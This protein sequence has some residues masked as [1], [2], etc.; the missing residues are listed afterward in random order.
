MCLVQSEKFEH[1]N[2]FESDLNEE[3]LIV[4]IFDV[5][6]MNLTEYLKL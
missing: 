5:S 1:F 3:I 6:L 2:H 4:P